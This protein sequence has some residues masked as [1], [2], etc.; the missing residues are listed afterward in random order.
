MKV[1]LEIVGPIHRKPEANPTEVELPEGSRVLDL[2][3]QLGYAAE[4][5]HLTYLR[6]GK[7]IKPYEL[8]QD[9]D[10]VQAV[11]HVGGG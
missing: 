7:L 3:G 10:R 11:L 1:S 6:Q 9:G 5:R 2:M 4:A 8:L